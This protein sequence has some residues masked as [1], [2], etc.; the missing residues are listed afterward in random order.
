MESEEIILWAI[1]YDLIF[2]A[3][4]QISM[5][6]NVE[7]LNIG[8]ATGISVYELKLKQAIKIIEDRI[9]STLGRELNVASMLVCEALNKALK[10]YHFCQV[11][12]LCLW[13][14][15]NVTKRCP[16]GK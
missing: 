1:H 9:K 6:E 11:N 13:W 4:I 15:Q 14:F 7:S 10:K 5:Q 2:D 16:R 3:R 12:S 8:V